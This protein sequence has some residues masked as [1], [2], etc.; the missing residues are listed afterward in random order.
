LLRKASTVERPMFKDILAKRSFDF[1]ADD[2]AIAAFDVA[3]KGKE[4][5]AMALAYDKL[6]AGGFFLDTTASV[7]LIGGPG[8]EAFADR[9]IATSVESIAAG[10]YRGADILAY[11]QFNGLGGLQADTPN[12]AGW[13]TLFLDVNSAAAPAQLENARTRLRG[14]RDRLGQ[15]QKALLDQ[16]ITELGLKL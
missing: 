3:G 4:W 14:M 11:Y 12:A 6:G 13:L 10:Y 15:S 1:A 5:A 16:I 7:F 8:T 9:I 2:A